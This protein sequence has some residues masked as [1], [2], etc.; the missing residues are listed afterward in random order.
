[1]PITA[2]K[3]MEH[4]DNMTPEER[5]RESARINDNLQRMAVQIL[6]RVSELAK[7]G[8]GLE[9]SQEA[10]VLVECDT[11]GLNTRFNPVEQSE[12]P[13]KRTRGPRRPVTPIVAKGSETVNVRSDILIQSLIHALRNGGDYEL[14]EDQGIAERTKRIGRKK[15]DQMITTIK[16]LE[17]EG[18]DVMLTAVNTLSDEC[19]DTYFALMA[20]ALEFNGTDRLPQRFQVTIEDI[21]S[22][23][24]KKKHHGSYD[25]EQMTKV[26]NHLKTLSQMHLIASVEV[27]RGKK[28]T[29]LTA[30]GPLIILTGSI[31]EY[32]MQGEKLYE[33][34]GIALGD[35]MVAIPELT[36][37]TAVM[38]RQVLTY[39]AKNKRYQKR[40]GIYLTFMFRNNARNGCTF[41]CSMSKLLAGAGITPERQIGRFKDAI[42][43][44][45]AEL[46]RDGVIGTYGPVV[47]SMPE[48]VEQHVNGWWDKYAQMQWRFEAPEAIKAHYRGLLKEGNFPG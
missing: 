26:L 3:L 33:K 44:A 48:D 19:V 14:Y 38:L 43:N 17:H 27:H 35:W 28:K 37:E 41:L 23:C 6:D 4:F 1:M 20:L 15:E 13:A 11:P 42:E 39:S 8:K 45:L 34:Y 46:Q 31:A 9:W 22:M 5:A 12:Q 30:K 18:F 21:L 24:G 16:P 32:N 25:P 29:T 7:E 47:D 40:L 36:R 10:G 2:K